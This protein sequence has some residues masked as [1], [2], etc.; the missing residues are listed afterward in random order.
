MCWKGSRLDISRCYIPRAQYERL[1]NLAGLCDSWTLNVFQ[2]KAFGSRHP[3]TGITWAPSPPF[4]WTQ[5]NSPIIGKDTFLISEHRAY[6]VVGCTL[7]WQGPLRAIRIGFT[8]ATSV[9]ELRHAYT[10]C[11]AFNG[12]NFYNFLLHVDEE[13]ALTQYYNSS[14]NG[15]RVSLGPV[16]PVRVGDKIA[17]RGNTRSLQISMRRGPNSLSIYIDDIEISRLRFG[18]AH[19]LPDLPPEMHFA[20][21]PCKV[22]PG[23]HVRLQVLPRTLLYEHSIPC[24]EY[25][26]CAFCVETEVWATSLCGRCILHW[27]CARH[28]MKCAECDFEGCAM[29]LMSHTH[30][31][32]I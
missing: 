13:N 22:R 9:R 30:S 31:F 7:A 10:A 20:M 12:V 24:I 16:F 29:C 27:H 1:A 17:R 5:P 26:P 21:K 25:R 8:N 4:V 19:G 32:T 6:A 15:N 11:T 18:W 23:D 28:I 3:L 14:W 2:A